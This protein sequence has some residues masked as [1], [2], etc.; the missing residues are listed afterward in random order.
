ML[1]LAGR[2]IILVIGSIGMSGGKHDDQN[3]FNGRAVFSQASPLAPI[4][5]I[6]GFAVESTP[7]STGRKNQ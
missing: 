2:V 6:I 5:V 4:V 7:S 3:V 1:I